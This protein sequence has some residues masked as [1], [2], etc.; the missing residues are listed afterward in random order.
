MLKSSLWIRWFMGCFM[1]LALASPSVAVPASPAIFITGTPG[2]ATDTPNLLLVALPLRNVG[3]TPA[4]NVQV[5]SATLVNS[6]LLAPALPQ[7]L[8]TLPTDDGAIVN[9]RFDA[10]ALLPGVS[11]RLTLSGTY[12]VAGVTYGF[13][14]NRNVAPP[15]AS[16]G[17]AGLTKGNTTSVAIDPGHFPVPPGGTTPPEAEGSNPIGIVVPSSPRLILP[18]FTTASSDQAAGSASPSVAFPINT[19]YG[20]WPRSSRPAVAAC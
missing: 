3:T 13:T 1:L 10:G 6:I 5:K 15:P 20:P 7:T 17:S 14:V 11:Y 12:Q 2:V 19:P 18:I 9:L 8:G 16:P 4:L